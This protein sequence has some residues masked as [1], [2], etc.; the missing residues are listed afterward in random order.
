MRNKGKRRNPLKKDPWAPITDQA[1][2]VAQKLIKAT[3]LKFNGGF[4]NRKFQSFQGALQP[5][6]D[7]GKF[8]IVMVEET[9]A[10]TVGFNAA[11][12]RQGN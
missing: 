11:W 8:I 2:L 12:Y 4:R 5:R 10:I 7:Q 1:F 9:I 6:V 3:N